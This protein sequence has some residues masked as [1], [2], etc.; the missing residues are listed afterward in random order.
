[1]VAEDE[2]RNRAIGAHGAELLAPRAR[3]CSRTATPARSRPRTSAPR[4]ASSS[5]RT[6]RA[7]S[8]T[9]G[10]TRRARCNQGGRLTAWE[11][12]LAGVPCALI[13]D[14][15]AA[16]VMKQRL[17][18][19]RHR[20]RR[21][22]RRQRRHRQQDRHLRPRRAR[23][24]ARHPVLRRR[25]DLHRRPHAV[26]R[27]RD[28]DRGARPA[29]GRRASRS[30]ARSSPTAPRRRA[31][32]TCSPRTGRY[33]VPLDQGP[34]RWRSRARAAAYSFDGWFRIAPPDIAVYNPAFDVTP[35][36]YITAIIT[37]R[38]VI[39]PEPRLRDVARRDVH[40]VGRRC[41]SLRHRRLRHR[42]DAG[43]VDVRRRDPATQLGHGAL[44]P[45]AGDPQLRRPSSAWARCCARPAC[46]ARGR[47]AAQ[48]VIIYVGLPALHLQARCT[49]HALTAEALRVVAV[50][51]VVFAVIG[52]LA[53]A[54]GAAR[55]SSPPRRAGGFILAAALGNTGYIGY[56]VTAALLGDG[57][58]PQRG[59]LR[60]VRHGAARWCSSGFSSPRSFGGPRRGARRPAARAADVP[61]GDRAVRRARCCSRVAVPIAVSDWLELLAKHGGA[62]HHDL[63]RAVAAAAGDRAGARCRSRCSRSLRLRRRA[64]GRARGRAR[65]A[66]DDASAL[67]ARRA[68][69]GHADR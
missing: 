28:R 21:P 36:E 34:R 56:P 63:G 25:A 19:R 20:R 30:R 38:G 13:A 49:A 65:A 40:G 10:S 26:D 61:G 18:R 39:R 31:R 2:E 5:P 15:M 50:A 37:E 44:G 54:R 24:G 7:R 4:S 23:Q 67:R 64:A 68:A 27:R 45:R 57:G 12:R 33:E 47:A 52:G 32:S 48:R 29:R 3:R 9:C 62:A 59:L 42:R 1:M 16:C 53:L 11:L 60:R 43:A 55:S 17:G 22:H 66:L 35:A 41:T 8:S 69:G 14:N 58:L 51:W 6:S 46:S